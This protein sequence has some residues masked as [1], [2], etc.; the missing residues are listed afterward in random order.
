MS[1][2]TPQL[3]AGMEVRTVEVPTPDGVVRG[4]VGVTTGPMGLT[5]LVRTACELTD[6]LVAR[7]NRLEEEAG[8]TISCRAG[9]GACCRHMAPVSAP[10]AFYLMDLVDSF[11]PA[12]RRAVIERF[13]KIVGV[14]EEHGMIDELLNPQHTDE[15]VLPVARKYFMLQTACPFL[16]DESCSIHPRRPVACRDYNVT[17]SAEWCSRPYERD[18]AKVPMPLPLSVSLARLTAA[19]AGDKP[20]LIPLTLVPR[21]VRAHGELRTRRWP[22]LELFD[23][24]LAEVG[25]QV[26][27]DR[28]DPGMTPGMP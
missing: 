21:W 11:E 28:T 19:V 4:K 22:G 25:S 5:G 16:A 15:P 2:P 26:P 20:C 9:C 6:A 3:P 17:S 14:L 24:F 23:R 27:S 12:R 10:E 13:D 18:I 8:R 1:D 7:A